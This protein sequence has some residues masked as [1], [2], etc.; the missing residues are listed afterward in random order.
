MAEFELA[1]EVRTVRG[2]KNR[3]LRQ[4]GY[5]PGIVYGPANDP[6]SFRTARLR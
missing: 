5:V 3:R 1:A 2:K 4:Q 6:I